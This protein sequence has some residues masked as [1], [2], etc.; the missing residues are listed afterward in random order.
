MCHTVETKLRPSFCRQ[1]TF[2]LM[3]VQKT[4]DACRIQCEIPQT[5][6]RARCYRRHSFSLCHHINARSRNN[7]SFGWLERRTRFSC[8]PIGKTI[9]L[10]FRLE[11]R[12]ACLMGE[13]G[14]IEMCVYSHQTFSFVVVVVVDTVVLMAFGSCQN[15]Q[16][17]NSN[18]VH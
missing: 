1:R 3:H 17:E 15:I 9:L 4:F 13:L 14:Y 10:N 18:S 7:G 11:I 6:M 5:R 12:L 8:W 16:M 2:S